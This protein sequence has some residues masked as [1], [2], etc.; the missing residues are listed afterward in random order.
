[1]NP[2]VRK[3]AERVAREVG[4]PPE[5]VL[6]HVQLPPKPD[7][8]EYALPC[9]PLAKVL[10]RPP[11]QLASKLACRFKP[12]EEVLAAEAAGPYLNFRVDRRAL[13]GYVLRE[14]YEKGEGY[15]DSDE[16]GGE[17]VVIDFSSPN[18]A[19]PFGV[20]HLRTTVIGWSLYRLYRALGYRTVGINHLGDW[21]TQFGKLIV[22]YM[23]WGDEE[24]LDSDPIG[25][26]LE[27]YV[28]FHEEAEGRPELEEEA[29]AWFRRL[30]EG[31]E[32][33][34]AL[35]ERFRELSLREFKK[36]Y[37]LMGVSFDYYWGESFYNGM[38]PEVV[39][40]LKEMGLAEESQGALIVDL[41]DYD[42]P[43]C[44]ILKSDEASLYATR[45]IAAAIYRWERF[46]FSK[47]L[48]VVG[49][50]QQLHFRQVFK[51]LELMGY[52]WADRCVHVPFGLMRF[53]HG[54]MSTRKGRIVLLEEVFGRAIELAKEIIEEKNPGLG[55]KEDVAR[56]VGVGA[57][58]FANLRGRRTKEA[59]FDWDEVLNFDGETGPYLQYTHA[60]LCSILRKYGREPSPDVDF[61]LLREPEEWEVLRLLERFP[62][63]LRSAANQ[64]EPGVLA[65]HMIDLAAAVNKFY[66]AHRVVGSDGELSDA[67][68]LLVHAARTVLAKGLYLL[69]MEAPEEM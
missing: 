24:A 6:P 30:E 3:I 54:K 28:K 26:M 66:N 8:G 7:L 42:M 23:L 47:M 12:D 35:W 31:D 37:D 46:R 39:R 55:N 48:Y 61:G 49:T 17:T 62:D 32:E 57:V 21:G 15:G 44:L 38:I 16:G 34:R 14:V 68:A 67:R 51:V 11:H 45:D 64:Y 59:V 10:G 25:H 40:R 50:D 27:L 65:G 20:H 19:K 60:R 43:P 58:V 53:R 52:E 2:F 41:S 13:A 9:F 4:L 33:A 1:M 5:E 18:I 22:A 69:G 36:V 29:K 56:K 63:A